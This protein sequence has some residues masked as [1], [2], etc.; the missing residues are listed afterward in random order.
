MSGLR[1]LWLLLYPAK[2]MWQ[3]IVLYFLRDLGRLWKSRAIRARIG[4]CTRLNTQVL[5]SKKL[6]FSDYEPTTAKKRIKKVKFLAEMDQVVP[7]PP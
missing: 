4:K 2:K 7:W 3:L 6:S 1:H 5:G